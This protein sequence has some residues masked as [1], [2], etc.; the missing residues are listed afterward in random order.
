MRAGCASHNHIGNRKDTYDLWRCKGCGKAACATCEGAADEMPD[1]C[2]DC[3]VEAQGQVKEA[4]MTAEQKYLRAETE[5]AMKCWI[6]LGRGVLPLS[7]FPCTNAHCPH[8][9]LP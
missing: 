6:C 7:L 8:R 3:W 9:K 1:H 5:P 2:D 4:P